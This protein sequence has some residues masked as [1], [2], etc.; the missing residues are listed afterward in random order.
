MHTYTIYILRLFIITEKTHIYNND[1]VNILTL[2]SR[3]IQTASQGSSEMW[4]CFGGGF[5]FIYKEQ[6]SLK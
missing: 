3:T 6:R 2:V 5:D 4:S 1:Y